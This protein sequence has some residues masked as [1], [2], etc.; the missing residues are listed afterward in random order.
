MFVTF[1]EVGLY[2]KF[3]F[4]KVNISGP[5]YKI[6]VEH[7]ISIQWCAYYPIPL[8]TIEQNANYQRK[9]LVGRPI[10][11]ITTVICMLISELV[12][13]D[14]P[15]VKMEP[16][17]SAQPAASCDEQTSAVVQMLPNAQTARTSMENV[18][19]N[20][21]LQRLLQLCVLSYLFLFICLIRST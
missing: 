8:I 2:I 7:I 13:S 1:C 11:V 12:T 20:M 9:F 3:W 14:P 6:Q 18:S 19:G 10:I 17:Q 15:I 21:T 4:K 5:C 16:S